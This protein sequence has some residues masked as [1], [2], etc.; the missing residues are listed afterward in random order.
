MNEGGFA[1]LASKCE[2][3][4][5]VDGDVETKLAEAPQAA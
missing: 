1:P 2:F 3:I 5:F 4:A